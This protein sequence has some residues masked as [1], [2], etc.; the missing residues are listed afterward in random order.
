MSNDLVE[1]S[2]AS[3]QKLFRGV[4]E[5]ESLQFKKDKVKYLMKKLNWKYEDIKRDDK[6]FTLYG[7]RLGRTLDNVIYNLTYD[8]TTTLR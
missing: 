4:S 5:L 7:D 1:L 2:E 3:L 6:G 8:N